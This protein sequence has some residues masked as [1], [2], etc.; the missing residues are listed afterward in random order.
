M[1]FC[2]LLKFL[3]VPGVAAP[4]GLA[5]CP[6]NG[7]TVVAMRH[8]KGVPKLNRPA[9]QRKALLRSLTTEIIRHGKVVTTKVT[10][11]LSGAVSMQLTTFY[12][13]CTPAAAANSLHEGIGH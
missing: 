8:R 3:R 5:M 13:I 10:A 9:D 7:G 1:H 2:N 6:T 11:S 4:S 12:N